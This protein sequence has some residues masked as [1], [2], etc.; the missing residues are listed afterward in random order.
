MDMEIW[1]HL[2]NILSIVFIFKSLSAL[3]SILGA[4]EIQAV[5]HCLCLLDLR[6]VGIVYPSGQQQASASV[7]RNVC[8]EC[9]TERTR[10]EAPS[11]R[12]PALN[13]ICQVDPGLPSSPFV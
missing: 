5:N 3:A 7:R 4:A 12:Q 11:Q 9:G 2:L 13:F 6:R 10:E 8:S 1:R